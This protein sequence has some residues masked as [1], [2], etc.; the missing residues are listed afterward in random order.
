MARSRFT[1]IIALA[2]LAAGIF[3]AP[4]YL[5]AADTSG[6]DPAPIVEGA[7]LMLQG[8]GIIVDMMAKKGFKDA[9]LMSAQKMMKEGYDMVI[10]GAGMMNGSTMDEGKSLVTKGA[11]MM[12]DADK[13]TSASVAKHGMVD[14]CAPGVEDCK[15]G[16]QKMKSGFQSY[17]LHG[18][19]EGQY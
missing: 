6:Q 2:F 4:L 13:L 3:V 9:E 11:K 17:G 7:K 5:S 1:S 8:N 18:D 16:T 12:M 10:K 15:K 14:E 19:W